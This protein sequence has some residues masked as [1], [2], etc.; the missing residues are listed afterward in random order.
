MKKIWWKI[1]ERYWFFKILGLLEI[2][3]HKK[4]GAETEGYSCG[5]SDNDT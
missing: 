3:F 5:E 1:L 2:Y 4:N